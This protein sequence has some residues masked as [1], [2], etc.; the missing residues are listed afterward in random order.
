MATWEDGPEYAPHQRPDQFEAPREATALDAAAPAPPPPPRAPLQPPTGYQPP[1]QV[2]P[3]DT[4]VPRTD[5]PRDPHRAFEVVSAMMTEQSAVGPAWNAAH[6]S[7]WAPPGTAPVPVPAAPPGHDP[8]QPF[9][10]TQGMRPGQ[11][12]PVPGPPLPAP[13]T[14]QWFSPVT[15]APPQVPTDD[16]SLLRQV[17]DGVGTPLLIFLAIGL[18]PILSPFAVVAALLLTGM[19]RRRRQQLRLGLL[20]GLG[21]VTLGG[22]VGFVQTLSWAGTVEALRS[23]SVLVCLAMLVAAPVISYLSIQAGEPEQRPQ[24]STRGSSSWG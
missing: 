4:L 6:S 14:D 5:V 20:I 18:I 7:S 10:A 3:L 16:R 13:G 2:A 22:M 1:Q 8:R 24:A 17:V 23:P 11:Q 19:A 15:W 9:V 12:P 21:F